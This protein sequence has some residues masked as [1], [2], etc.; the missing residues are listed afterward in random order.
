MVVFGSVL[1]AAGEA[2]AQ[3]SCPDEYVNITPRAEFKLAHAVFV[4]KVVSVNKGPR[5][6]DDHYIYTVT[7]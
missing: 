7:F 3:C 6:K 2:R 5:D 4:G 1:L